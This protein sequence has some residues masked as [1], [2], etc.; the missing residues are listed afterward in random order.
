MNYLHI[1][2]R[3]QGSCRGP[4]STKETKQYTN[5]SFDRGE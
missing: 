4:A 5:A 3:T 1:S 2:E